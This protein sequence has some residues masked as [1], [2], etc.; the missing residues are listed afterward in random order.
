MAHGRCN[1]DIG[2]SE[3]LGKAKARRPDTN[4][5]TQ[6]RSGGFTLIEFVITTIVIGILSAVVMIGVSARTGHRANVQADEFRRN[7]SRLQLLAISQGT[8]LK[9]TVTSSNYSVYCLANIPGICTIGSLIKD[10]VTQEL[11]SVNLTDGINFSAG[12]GSYYFDSLGRPV[13]AATGASLVTGTS[14]F[15]L[16]DAAGKV[17]VNVTLT[18]ITG[19][20]QRS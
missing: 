19:F 1:V 12:L 7:L 20:A 16:N 17:T 9:L 13:A 11:F 8:R 5:T 15:S 2:R 10:P 3:R 6:R 18:P 4:S 14:T